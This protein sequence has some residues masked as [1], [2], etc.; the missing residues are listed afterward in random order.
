MR[1]AVCSQCSRSAAP[2]RPAGSARVHPRPAKGR[3]PPKACRRSRPTLL[4]AE[5]WVQPADLGLLLGGDTHDRSRCTR[6][7]TPPPRRSAPRHRSART[8]MAWWRERSREPSQCAQ[9]DEIAAE[10]AHRTTGRGCRNV[11]AGRGQYRLFLDFIGSPPATE[12]QRADDRQRALSGPGHRAQRH[13]VWGTLF[14]HARGDEAEPGPIRALVITV[15]E[16]TE[17]ALLVAGAGGSLAPPP[18]FGATPE[19]AIDLP[20]VAASADVEHHAAPPAPALPKAV[21]HCARICANAGR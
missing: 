11:S 1:A 12:G 8:S 2:A 18:G 21:V 16:S 5:L 4:R 7:A 19:P 13:P 9:P 14:R 6:A 17:R 20:A 10:A 3:T 15:V